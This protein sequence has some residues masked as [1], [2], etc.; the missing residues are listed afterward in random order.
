MITLHFI[1]DVE[2]SQHRMRRSIEEHL[3]SF[4]HEV[5]GNIRTTKDLNSNNRFES[6]DLAIKQ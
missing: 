3:C 4:T 5:H 2:T 6:L 1:G